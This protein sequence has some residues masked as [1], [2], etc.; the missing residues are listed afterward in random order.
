[1]TLFFGMIDYKEGLHED[2]HGITQ[3]F[4]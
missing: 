2:T 1:M 4:F 3:R